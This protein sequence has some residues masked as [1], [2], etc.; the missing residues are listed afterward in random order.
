[1]VGRNFV[2]QRY[3]PWLVGGK[4]YPFPPRL[5]DMEQKTQQ[6]LLIG[7]EKKECSQQRLPVYDE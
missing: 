3:E 1:M 6:I 4:P 2:F 5:R 7:R